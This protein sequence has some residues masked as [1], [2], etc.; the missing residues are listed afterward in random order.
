MT[1]TEYTIQ[2]TWGAREKMVEKR[3][4]DIDALVVKIKSLLP[5]SVRCCQAASMRSSCSHVVRTAALSM[6]AVAEVIFC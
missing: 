5:N 4:R 6:Q 2:T 3:F 1:Y